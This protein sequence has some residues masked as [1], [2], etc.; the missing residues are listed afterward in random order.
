M[1]AAVLF[2]WKPK[3]NGRE[4]IGDPSSVVCTHHTSATAVLIRSRRPTNPSTGWKRREV[5]SNPTWRTLGCLAHA[6]S[7]LCL[8]RF[9]LFPPFATNPSLLPFKSFSSYVPHPPSLYYSFPGFLFHS[10]INLSPL[11]IP[12]LAYQARCPPPPPPTNTTTIDI[13]FFSLY[14]PYET[15]QPALVLQRAAVDCCALPS[16]PCSFYAGFPI[17]VFLIRAAA[18]PG[19]YTSLRRHFLLPP[20]PFSFLDRILFRIFCSRFLANLLLSPR[21]R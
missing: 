18:A 13:A 9:L 4:T 11:F 12:L 14:H 20:L 15:L 17:F 16:C 21:I 3:W 5:E 1:R 7:P 19:Y 6:E 2:G 8:F 10:D